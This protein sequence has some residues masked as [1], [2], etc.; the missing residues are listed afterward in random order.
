[1]DQGFLDSESRG[2]SDREISFEVGGTK[3][4]KSVQTNNYVRTTRYTLLTFIPLTLFENFQRLANVYFLVIATLCFVPWSPITPFIS[5]TPLVFVIG[6]SMLKAL[7]EDL[8]RYK[9]DKNFNSI[10]FQVYRNGE[11]RHIPSSN[12]RPGDIIKICGKKECPCDC[13]VVA[14]SEPEGKCYV[15]EVNLNGETAIKQKNA[16]YCFNYIGNNSNIDFGRFRNCEVRIP[17]PSDDLRSLT[18]VIKFDSEYMGFEIK[19]CLLKGTIS[20]HTEWVIAIALYTGHDTRIVQNSRQAPFKK[21]TLESRFNMIIGIDFFLNF[22]IIFICSIMATIKEKS[23]NFY[24]VEVKSPS[25]YLFLQYLTAYAVIFS[26][27]IP[28]SLYVTVEFVRFFQRWTF[29]NDL[30]M[31]FKELGY[32]TP[33]NSNLNEELGNVDYI[34][35]DKTG[36]LTENIMKFARVTTRN[37]VYDV[38]KDKESVQRVINQDVALKE[39]FLG[40]LVCNTAIITDNGY[41]SESPEEEALL[42]YSKELNACLVSRNDR[43]LT[44]S[45]AGNVETFDILAVI[46]FDSDRKRMSIILRRNNCVIIYTKGADTV[47]F[48]LISQNEEKNVRECNEDQINHFASKGLRTLL[49]GYRQLSS[50]E[51][52]QFQ[53]EYKEACISTYNRD[54]MIKAAGAKLEKDLNLLGSVAIEDQLQTRVPETIAFLSRMGI[55]LWVLTGDKRETAISIAKSTNIITSESKLFEIPGNH[56]EIAHVEK[57]RRQIESN[58]SK[59]LSN[60]LILSPAAL[61]FLTSSPDYSSILANIGEQ[62]KSVICFR[63]SPKM[64]SKVV[65]VMRTHTKKC[66]LAIGDGANDVNMIQTS[67]IGIGIV[68]RE[69]RQAAQNS[70]FAIT[71]FMHIRKLL[72]VHGRL[73]LVRLSGV[74]RYMVYKNLVFVLPQLYFFSYTNWTPSSLFDGWLLS[75]YNLFWTI[76][77]PGQYGFFE[78]DISQRSMMEYPII[79]SES[80]S[81]RYISWSMFLKEALNAIYQSFVLFFFNIVLPTRAAMSSNGVVDNLVM[82]GVMLY[83]AIVLVVDCQTI[84]RSHHWNIFLLLGVVLS[85]LLF[86]L[87]NLP[88]GSFPSYVPDMYYVP[89]TIFTTLTPYFILVES[90]LISLFPEAIIKYLWGLWYPSTTRKIRE[91]EIK[92]KNL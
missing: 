91:K 63:M 72:A 65:D 39:M 29:M 2:E 1:M 84:I 16:L 44:V 64:K 5:L 45:I 21:S 43:S 10:N 73:S 22:L 49:Y 79:Y 55:R 37:D 15:N 36:T 77:P 33:N 41:S 51:Y 24:W 34:F 8:I 3:F 48:D 18:G 35:S 17:H 70:D 31:Y 50:D 28:V 6:V 47:L 40:I 76:F 82:N 20:T 74:V 53:K 86:F 52:N 88:Y 58:R 92:G 78:Q 19:N 46:D 7:F 60:V 80:K 30:G 68:G 56:I 27:M 54:A 81:G 23:L 75:T 57:L 67:N 26:Y 4:P 42:T 61:E 13:L 14:T 71:R 85:I 12:I 38:V 32:C 66:C 69:G 90:V 89:Q 59:K 87:I 62:C 25:A 83:T 11:F 9:T